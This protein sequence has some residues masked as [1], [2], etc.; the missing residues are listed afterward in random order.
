MKNI[1]KKQSN[2]PLTTIF[3]V[4]TVMIFLIILSFGFREL[5]KEIGLLSA[6]IVKIVTQK[7][8]SNGVVSDDQDPEP[9]EPDDSG[10]DDGIC[11]FV[12]LTVK[13]MGK[14]YSS[15]GDQLG[16]G[17][18]PPVVDIPTNVWIFFEIENFNGDLEK[19][20]LTAQLPENVVWTNKKSVL[21]GK[22]NFGQI[23]KRVVWEVDLVDQKD[24]V[25]KT[26]F[27]ISLIPT[28]SDIGKVLDLV[29][30]IKFRAIE[31]S[32]QSEISGSL[33]NITTDL[34]FDPLASGKGTVIKQLIF[35]K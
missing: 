6:N 5:T 32:C 9:T 28:Q 7:D 29:T 30:D 4:V 22:L 12:P 13:A 20:N 33:D 31:Q 8:I 11:E 16:V 3:A 35:D 26:G 15:Q 1:F 14:Y 19:F 24:K 18:L 27:E 34:I 2:Y 23:G 21:A 25:Y 17:P 10:L